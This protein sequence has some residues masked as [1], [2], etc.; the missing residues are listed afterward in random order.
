MGASR[1]RMY[2]I[3][4][5]PNRTRSESGPAP[6]QQRRQLIS[7]ELREKLVG[8]EDESRD[9]AAEK[10]EV[11]ICAER[12]RAAA[13]AWTKMPAKLRFRFEKNGGHES[14]SI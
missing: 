5:C 12:E 7:V 14:K 11:Q 2:C 13:R 8:V 9:T 1:F 10:W 6:K 3:R 4:R